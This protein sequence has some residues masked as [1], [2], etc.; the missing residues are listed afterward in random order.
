MV[1]A[2]EAAHRLGMIDDDLLGRHREVLRTAGLPVSYPGEDWASLRAAMSLD[3][4]T[5][6]TTL[7]LV[8]LTGLGRATIVADAAEDVLADSYNALVEA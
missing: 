2:A 4:K 6:G 7:R 1:F 3:K 8:L 5:R